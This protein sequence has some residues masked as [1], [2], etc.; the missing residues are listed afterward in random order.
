M[1]PEAAVLRGADVIDGTGAPARRVDV[2]IADGR[3]VA[4]GST[5]GPVRGGFLTVVSTGGGGGGGGGVCVTMSTGGV[6][7]AVGVS[8]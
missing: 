4:V 8:R 6:S 1:S 5:A 3:I 2:A 7:T